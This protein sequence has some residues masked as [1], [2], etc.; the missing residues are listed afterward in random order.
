[1]TAGELRDI[2]EGQFQLARLG[3][4]APRLEGS[5]PP[6]APEHRIRRP[7]ASWRAQTS[8][9]AGSTKRSGGWDSVPP[10]S[11]RREPCRPRRGAADRVVSGLPPWAMIHSMTA[12]KSAPSARIAARSMTTPPEACGRAN[13]A[14]NALISASSTSHTVVLPRCLRVPGQRDRGPWKRGL[15]SVT[16]WRPRSSGHHH[17][18]RALHR[19][20]AATS[21]AA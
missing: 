13:R 19:E 17:R 1:M 6:L 20:L 5:R 18:S 7:A 11:L 8:A 14:T 4:E 3:S 12:E 2:S 9:P 10:L 15:V 16:S 21:L